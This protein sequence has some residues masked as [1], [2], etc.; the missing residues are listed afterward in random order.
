MLSWS[1][2]SSPVP[3]GTGR[4]GLV[5]RHLPEVHYPQSLAF[6]GVPEVR[7]GSIGEVLAARHVPL[8]P[9]GIDLRPRLL[10]VIV[11]KG[12]RAPLV[13][14]GADFAIHVE[15]VEQHPAARD[16]VRIRRHGVVEDRQRGVAIALRDV[17]EHLIVGAVLSDHIDDVLDGRTGG[18]AERRTEACV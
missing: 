9:V 5:G 14:V 3:V 13:P 1:I 15:V 16:R 12:A 2:D 10:V 17:A 8:A 4:V 6:G 7:L 11:G 18:R